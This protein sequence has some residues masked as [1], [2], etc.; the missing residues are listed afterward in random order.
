MDSC[1]GCKFYK[2]PKPQPESLA[3][4]GF[5][6]HGSCKRYPVSTEKEPDDFCGEFKPAAKI[7][8]KR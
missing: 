2:P 8:R 5:V 1:G 3:K 7:R 4:T 6:L